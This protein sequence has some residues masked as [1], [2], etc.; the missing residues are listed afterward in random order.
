MSGLEF[1]STQ[2]HLIADL[3]STMAKEYRIKYI[4]KKFMR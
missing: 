4:G 2:V 3:T 1:K